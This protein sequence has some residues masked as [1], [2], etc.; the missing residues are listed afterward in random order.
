MQ[1]NYME[2]C[3]IKQQNC[4][5]CFNTVSSKFFVRIF[6]SQIALKNMRLKHDLPTSVNSRMIMPFH[7]GFIFVKLHIG[8]VLQK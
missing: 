2:L 1:G 6:N 8:K 7:E 3:Y 5:Y 4:K